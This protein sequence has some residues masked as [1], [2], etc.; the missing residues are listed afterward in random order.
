MSISLSL[1]CAGNNGP[2]THGLGGEPH[3]G[4]SSGGKAGPNETSSSAIGFVS[5][6]SFDDVFESTSSTGICGP[7]AGLTSV[8]EQ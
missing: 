4:R 1:R 5:A 7:I 2:I 8:H 6:M 3:S